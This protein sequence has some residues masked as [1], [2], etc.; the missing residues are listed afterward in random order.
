MNL[1]KRFAIPMRAPE[2]PVLRQVVDGVEEV[3]YRLLALPPGDFR[4][5]GSPPIDNEQVGLRG[6]DLRWSAVIDGTHIRL[7]FPDVSGRRNIR[8]RVTSA[9]P[10]Q[11]QVMTSRLPLIRDQLDTKIAELAS[12]G[13]R[14]IEA[15][16][17]LAR[18][19]VTEVRV[20]GI[21]FLVDAPDGISLRERRPHSLGSGLTATRDAAGRVT[22][23]YW[24]GFSFT[25]LSSIYG[26]SSFLDKVVAA[27]D[28]AIAKSQER[29]AMVAQLQAQSSAQRAAQTTAFE[30]LASISSRR[31]GTTSQLG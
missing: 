25:G 21:G 7:T 12:F 31:I 29:A 8:S 11:I 16:N 27:V 13:G 22:V 26:E 28:S 17:R 9:T 3:V 24:P 6:D 10:S 14:L 20:D 18:N 4:I 15:G 5:P 23:D 1:L 2:D 30:K 19:G